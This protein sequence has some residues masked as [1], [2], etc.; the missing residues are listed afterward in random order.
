MVLKLEEFDYNSLIDW[1]KP[2]FFNRRNSSGSSIYKVIASANKAVQKAQKLIDRIES[3]E[4]TSK[5]NAKAIP[6]HATIRKEFV[7]C[8][9][10]RCEQ[11]PHGPY[12]YAYWKERIKNDDDS[13]NMRTILKKKYIGSRLTK[14]G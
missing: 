8:G 10:L 12:F 9:K 7:K 4:Q 3:A 1:N 5:I 13:G 2:L 14:A 11:E 6:D